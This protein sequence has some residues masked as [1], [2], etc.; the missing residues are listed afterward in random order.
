MW[1][2]SECFVSVE[3]AVGG[4]LFQL[5]GDSIVAVHLSTQHISKETLPMLEIV[6]LKEDNISLD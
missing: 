3:A 1:V 6:G 2:V 4:D 5:T